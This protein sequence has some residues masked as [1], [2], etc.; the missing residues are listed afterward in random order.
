[1]NGKT[2]GKSR[3]LHKKVDLRTA[4]K[5][6]Y[7]SIDRASRSR[8]VQRNN[9][10]ESI[11]MDVVQQP[12]GSYPSW[13]NSF[14]HW[15]RS[16]RTAC[17]KLGFEWSQRLVVG[18]ATTVFLEWKESTREKISGKPKITLLVFLIIFPSTWTG[19]TTSSRKLP[20]RLYGSRQ[21]PLLGCSGQYKVF[22]YLIFF[23]LSLVQALFF[24]VYFVRKIIKDLNHEAQIVCKSFLNRNYLKE[25]EHLSLI[26]QVILHSVKLL[27]IGCHQFQS[28]V[29]HCTFV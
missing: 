3:D 4:I 2:G 18:P 29:L 26:T 23:F 22:I 15:K 1:M 21:H 24:F 7:R 27:L 16:V 11:Y 20:Q 8:S 9:T 14:K 19:C 6:Q 5:L 12:C 17:I 28:E 10:I 25:N 13:T